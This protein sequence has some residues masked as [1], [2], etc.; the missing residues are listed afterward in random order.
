MILLFVYREEGLYVFKLPTSTDQKAL[1]A[2]KSTHQSELYHRRMGHLN[3]QP[4]RL[5]LNLSS[6]IELD[7]KPDHHYVPCIQAKSRRSSF[8]ASE[9]HAS[10]VGFLIHTGVCY[11]DIPTI[12]GVILFIDNFSRYTYVFLLRTKAYAAC[13]CVLSL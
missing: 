3:Y 12:V 1:A 11:I 8:P 13:Q 6:G 4:L 10:H 5:L 7:N 9:S 2:T